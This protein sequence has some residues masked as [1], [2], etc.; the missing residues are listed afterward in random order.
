MKTLTVKL[1]DELAVRLE[2]RARQFGISKS[3]LVRESIE[4]DLTRDGRV[5]E[6]PSIYELVKDDLGCFDSGLGDLST[7]PRHMEGFGE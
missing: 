4:R 5:E 7:D 2:K 3:A 1:P 6:Q